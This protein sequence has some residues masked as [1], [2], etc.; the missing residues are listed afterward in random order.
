MRLPGI[1]VGVRLLFVL[2][3]MAAFSTVLALVV[4]ERSLASDL[5]ETARV[6]LD[7]SAS[8]ASHLVDSHLRS[9]T[10]RYRAI[11]GTPELRANLEVEHSP[12]LDY[13][14]QNLSSRER[15][16]FVLFVDSH[17]RVAGFGGDHELADLTGPYL[18]RA[19]SNNCDPRYDAMGAGTSRML[20]QLG[21][22]GF[23][24]CGRNGSGSGSGEAALW[25]HEDAYFVFSVVP[26]RHGNEL[27]GKLIALEPVPDEL[28]TTW[29]RLI[30]APLS[31]VRSASSPLPDFHRTVR[32][33]GAHELRIVGSMETELAAF[34]NARTNLL[35][36]GLV[37]LAFAFGASLVLA[38][39]LVRPIR[40]IQSATERIAEGDFESRLEI[41]RQ[42]EFGEVAATFNAMLDRLESSRERVS[43]AQR[44]ARVGNWGLEIDSGEL[45]YS[46]EFLRIF[47]LDPNV[48]EIVLK[49]LSERVHPDDRA[50]FE[51]AIVECAKD[52][53]PFTLDHRAITGNG[54]ERI[55]HTQAERVCEAER[56]V[57]LEGTVQDVTERKRVEEQVR[58]LAYHDSLTG[59]GN[60]LFF[61]ERLALALR[62]ANLDGN[63]VVLMFLDI[64]NFKVINDTLGHS[65]GDDLLRQ[66]ADCLVSRL[67]SR[68][69]VTGLCE[70]TVC[71]IGGDEFTIL[72]TRA[73]DRERTERVA[74]RVLDTL[75]RPFRVKD[76]E[77]IVGASIGITT[78]PRDGRDVETLLRNSD[79]AMYHAKKKGRNNYQFYTE[80]MQ[81]SA[82]KRMKL[83]NKLR[84]ALDRGEFE[85]FY[86]PKVELA[87]GRITGLEALVR[88]QDPLVGFVLPGEFIPLAEE[89]G[90]IR[91]IGEW[92]LRTAAR[93]TA[94]WNAEGLAPV[95]I[96][97][98]LSP[99]QIEDPG[100]LYMVREILDET[101]L[102]PQRLD[103]EIT[104]N[105][106]MEDEEA[107]INVLTELK[108]M[109]VKLSLDDFGTGYSS[110]SYL[111]VLPIDTLKIDRSFVSRITADEDDAALVGAIVSMAKVLRL[112]VVVEG[113][114]TEE[115]R[116]CLEELGCDEIQ[117]FLFSAAL[118]APAMAAFLAEHYNTVKANSRRHERRRKKR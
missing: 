117:G 87:T 81:E 52:G 3:A 41:D 94:Q 13:Y 74:E 50:R 31:I 42:D 106:L 20:W 83:E 66:V 100:F 79:T 47:D 9:V 92:V 109:G 91:G 84:G 105:T 11:S 44:L 36:A 85:V 73:G 54:A 59:L 113:V 68:N 33:I 99:Q 4:Q 6:R 15:A 96:S 108:S 95:C 86:Q 90:S 48:E 32:R 34:R 98:N 103:F 80:A 82:F 101:G 112:R 46:A 25:A 10:A 75:G 8:F 56:P 97:V 93:Q 24:N 104:E 55:L 78:W 43:S 64:D 89:I 69:S 39:A 70:I 62:Q 7:R 116:D 35:T 71:R 38:R 17:Q 1:T 115:Q 65:A 45:H 118:P 67:G 40:A 27:L 88:W 53:K 51:Q 21:M 30:G 37:A 2:C 63:G 5:K 18:E 77:V 57:R 28:L 107:V 110:L 14:A 23:A 72:M 76:Q 16:S 61:K 22:P 114:E 26:I 58:Y 49:T 111:R 19:I 12:T 102:D 60:R 29:S